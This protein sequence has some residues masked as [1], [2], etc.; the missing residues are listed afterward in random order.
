MWCRRGWT[1][2]FASPAARASAA[3]AAKE[4]TR[5]DLAVTR[6][7][8]LDLLTT[9]DRAGTT[10]AFERYVVATERLSAAGAT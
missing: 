2:R 5:L 1:S 4:R 7:L 10:R 8:L 6:G 3:A 9:G